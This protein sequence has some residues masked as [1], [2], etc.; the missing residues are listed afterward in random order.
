MS[1][2]FLL[3]VF[4]FG[5]FILLDLAD[6]LFPNQRDERIYK[7]TSEDVKFGRW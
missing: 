4:L 2:E 3:F 1:F 5:P 7:R 6:F